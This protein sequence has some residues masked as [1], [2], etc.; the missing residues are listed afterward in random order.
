MYFTTKALVVALAAGAVAMPSDAPGGG[1]AALSKPKMHGKTPPMG[2]NMTHPKPPSPGDEKEVDK[3]DF[4]GI[5][6]PNITDLL[7]GLKDNVRRSEEGAKLPGGPP[8]GH[9]NMT[10]PTGLRHSAK[11]CAEKKGGPK[12]PGGMNMTRP[13]GLR[14]RKATRAEKGGKE[15]D[16]DTEDEG[17]KEGGDDEE[18]G[19]PKKP[20]SSG[21]PKPKKPEASGVP[22]PKKPEASGAPKPKKPEEGAEEGED[23]GEEGGNGKRKIHQ[24]QQV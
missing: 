2:G 7:S 1:A 6:F 9:R 11:G 8:P 18:G 4:L 15:G 14:L 5:P 23:D 3:R 13:A 21:A 10:K 22:K 19:A 17:G 20:E 24:R 16:R 12:F